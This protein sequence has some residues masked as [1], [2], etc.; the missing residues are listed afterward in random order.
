M[1]KTAIV[2]T[3]VLLMGLPVI[4]VAGP[5][6]DGTYT[7]TDLGGPMLTGRYSESWSMA[8]GRLQVGNTTNNLSW[9]GATLGTQWWMYCADVAFAPFMISDTV[10]NGNGF[11]EWLVTYS[12]G[13]MILDGNG[14]WGDGS[15][16][17]Y[18]ATFHSYSEIKTFQ[19]VD[20]DILGVVSTVNLQAGIIGWD[21]KCMALSISNQEE[22][23]TT[24]G[25]PQPLNYPAFLAP[26][27]CAPTRTLGSWGESDEFTLII[28]GCTVPTEQM[29]WGGIK[30]LYN[31]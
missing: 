17:S 25:G 14:P 30:S 15:E 24:D 31:E 4:A 7:S 21:E 8:N 29:T 27:T 28:T 13:I 1:M 22:H 6:L 10:V 9:D 19:F 5:P 2:R 23:G 12:G 16:P 20:G 18:T 11:Q 26:A 3:L